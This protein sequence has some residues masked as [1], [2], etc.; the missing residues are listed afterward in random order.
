MM[1]SLSMAMMVVWMAGCASTGATTA[2]DDSVDLG[3]EAPRPKDQVQATAASQPVSFKTSRTT[4]VRN[5]RIGLTLVNHTDGPVGYDLCYTRMEMKVEGNWHVAEDYPDFCD[6][7]LKVLEAGRSADYNVNMAEVLP[8]GQYRVLTVV[9]IPHGGQRQ[10][11]HT[12]D[13]ELRD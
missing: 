6:T 9:E 3:V 7:E 11:L 5:D 4:F 1:R 12:V 8:A 10:T 13:L 2:N